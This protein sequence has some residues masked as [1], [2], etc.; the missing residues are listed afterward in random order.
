MRRV[1]VSRI[2]PDG[3]IHARRNLTITY[4]PPMGTPRV[5]ICIP[6]YNYA[7][8]IGEALRSACDQTYRDIEI[9][10]IDDASTDGTVA[11]VEA[12]ARNEPRVRLVRN[13]RNLGL[14]ANYNRCIEL[15]NAPLVKILCAD[16]LLTPDC[17]ERMV[18]VLDAHPEVSLVACGR[19]FVGADREHRRVERYARQVVIEPGQQTLRRCFYLGNLIGEPTAVMFRRSRAGTGFN[20]NY[21]QILDLELWLRIVADNW[22]AALPE[23]LCQFRQHQD[24]ATFKQMDTGLIAADRVRL[25]HDYH[26]HPALRGAN[27]VERLIWDARMAWVLGREPSTAR[28][29]QH[30]RAG[31]AVYFPVLLPPLVGAGRLAT[32]MGLGPT[33]G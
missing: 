29:Y 13:P 9:I 18:C 32:S 25:F 31:Q 12:I 28:N 23:A 17:V 27:V 16:D 30:T 7:H 14:Q 10:V 15:A 24:R 4:N 8:Y 3:P 33:R 1:H 21:K 2:A 20:E 19:E 11:V 26:L 6:T 5:S 22:F